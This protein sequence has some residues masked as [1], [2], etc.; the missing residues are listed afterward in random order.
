MSNTEN[1]I[2]AATNIYAEPI[3]VVN[4]SDCHFYHTVELPELGLQY[5]EWDLRG[6]FDRY[7]GGIAFE[8]KRVL[9]VG[10]GSGFL[11]I[12]AEQRGA[13]E[14]VSFDMDDSR[15]QHWLPFHSKLA[16]RS[17]AEFQA[18]HNRWI[19]Q[20]RNAYWLTHRLFGSKAKAI[21]GDIY[22]FPVEAGGFDVVLVCS[23]LEHLSDPIR[24]LASVCKVAASEL[25]ITGPVLETE[26]NIARFE[27]DSS[28][29]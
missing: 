15:R 29:P 16:Y 14:V 25:V 7:V 23:I 20:W 24:A 21:Y 6:D 8:G 22:N 18:Q 3:F 12:S 10:C 1:E 28:R 5:G 26:E 13:R 27:G 2:N 19:A 9:D 11:S 4:L 17:P